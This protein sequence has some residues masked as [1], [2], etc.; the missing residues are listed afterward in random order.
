MPAVRVSVPRPSEARPPNALPLPEA[1]S[2]LPQSPLM[3]TPV[4]PLGLFHTGIPSHCAAA[5]VARHAA[6]PS[7]N[8]ARISTPSGRLV[9]VG[10]GWWR[11]TNLHHPPQPPSVQCTHTAPIDTP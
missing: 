11:I 2:G 3:V 4:P 1:E 9:E 6:N 8:T 5:G 10:G 7:V